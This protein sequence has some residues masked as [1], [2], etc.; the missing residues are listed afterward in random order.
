MVYVVDTAV[1]MEADMVADIPLDMVNMFFLEEQADMAD[2]V[3][4]GDKVSK[5]FLVDMA[6]DM[7]EDMAADMAYMAS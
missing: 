4:M 2:K 7:A 5:I 3:D 1:G 6:G